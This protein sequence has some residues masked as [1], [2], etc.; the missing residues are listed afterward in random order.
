MQDTSTAAL[1]VQLKVLDLHQH[2]VQ[3]HEIGAR[4][5]DALVHSSS[6]TLV[7]R[8]LPAHSHNQQV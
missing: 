1:T 4:H 6:I 7:L 5:Q 8:N 2:P 3:H